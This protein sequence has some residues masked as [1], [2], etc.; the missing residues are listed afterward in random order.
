[1]VKARPSILLIIF[2]L[3]I[4]ALYSQPDT[5]TFKLNSRLSFY[6][7]EKNGELLLHIPD[8]LKFSN[9]SVSI[10]CIDDSL[11]F[12][13]GTPGKTLLRIPVSTDLEPSYHT[14]DASISVRGRDMEY[15]CRTSLVKLPYKSNEVK[16]D[17]LTGGLIV[18]K[19]QFFP[20]GFY[21]Y[22]PV[23]P[24]LPEEEVIRGF[25]IISPYQRVLP[26]TFND[27][28]NY[29]DR[30]A[31]LGMKV[32]YNLL[33]VAGGG[34][35]NSVIEGISH[36]TKKKLLIDEILAFRDHP[37]LLAW[38]IADEP[39]GYSIHPDTLAD[40]YRTVKELDPW[41][42]VSIVFN[43][44]VLA[45]IKYSGAM[46]IVMADPYPVPVASLLLP[47]QA[48]GQLTKEFRGSKPVWIVPQAFG[49]GEWWERE[50]TL[51]E[52]R[53]MT[54]QSIIKGARGIQ[55][56]VRSGPNLFP[57]SVPAWSEA[58]RM[59]IE[60]AELT[61]WLL[62]EEESPSVSTSSSNILV[63]SAVHDGQLM[64]MVV[65]TINKPVSSYLSISNK[66][67]G[68]AKVIFENRSIQVN[69][70]S[71]QDQLSAY[72]SQVYLIKMSPQAPGIKPWPA[73]LTI[74]PGFENTA[75]PG[76]PS[77]LYARNNG[78]RGATY[79]TDT[80]EH[81]EGNHS[82]RLVT[83]VDKGSIRLRFFPVKVMQGQTYTIS[84]WAKCDPEQG[85][86]KEL[87]TG[88]YFEIMMADFAKKQFLLSEEWQQF[89]TNVTIPVNPDLPDR[90]NI[91]L[92]M[93]SAGVAWFDM[94]QVAKSYD[95]SRSVNPFLNGQFLP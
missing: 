43:P 44:P 69:G 77:A 5:V 79:F 60:I 25:N 46:D 7:W 75:S 61:P 64:I 48:A 85:L 76:V 58:G 86:N 28:M 90:I 16:A 51:Q 2:N 78:A 3:L 73:N 15:R 17:R 62:S 4:S 42:P 53:T 81:V 68:T 70:G 59:A 84:I 39:N 71:F 11:G 72:G 56:F 30:C 24:Q 50:P 41:H 23:D 34:G 88:K 63:H 26:E 47:G 12:Y 40:I 55:Y 14:V 38:Y 27:R 35:V 36:T 66:I 52:L 83:P 54:Y 89:V 91:T 8:K 57:K 10:T 33:S 93:K 49:G 67:S 74:D 20:F 92:Q 1:M 95:I 31:G 32:H 6:S 37:A 18:N 94:I 9:I 45:A 29:M 82:V 21:C 87:G 13:N 65:N 80:R 19:R 22:S